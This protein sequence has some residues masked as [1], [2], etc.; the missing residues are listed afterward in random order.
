MRDVTFSLIVPY[1]G[2][3]GFRTELWSW[4][5]RWWS[6][7]FPG[8]EIITGDTEDPTFDRGTSRN[9]AVEQATSDILVIADADTIPNSGAV[10]EA[11]ALVR[12]GAPWVLPYGEERYYNLTEPTTWKILHAEPSV[13]VLEPHVW[14]HKLTSWAGCLVMSREAFLSVG[15][16]DERFV[17]WGYED[18]AFRFAMDTLVGPHVRVD[19]YACHLWHPIT[20][21]SNFDQ[22]HIDHNRALFRRYERASG[23][24]DLMRKVLS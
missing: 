17:G 23:N 15:G 19:S 18:N 8:V 16:Y 2:N 3:G 13:T 22:P 9:V 20:P 24:R 4:C 21:G 6:Y 11:L 1:R 12:E 7:R 14:E 10:R 5:R